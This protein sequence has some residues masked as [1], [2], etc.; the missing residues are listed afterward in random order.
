MYMRTRP[1]CWFNVQEILPIPAMAHETITILQPD[2]AT[3]TMQEGGN[4]SLDLA[5]T[6]KIDDM[7]ITEHSFVNL[8]ENN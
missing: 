7:L 6:L 5:I 8:I 2:L 1:L 4:H 3:D